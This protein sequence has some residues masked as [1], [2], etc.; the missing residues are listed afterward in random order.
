VPDSALSQYFSKLD[1]GDFKGCADLFSDDALY[2][3]PSPSATNPDGTVTPGALAFVSGR[4][5]IQAFFEEPGKR[6]FHHEIRRGI[7][8]TSSSYCEGLVISE[9]GAPLQLFISDALLDSDGRITRYVG[10]AKEVT[11][12]E[13]GQLDVTAG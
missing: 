5:A 6:S 11:A 4:Q 7:T 10:L 13:A 9:D 1:A 2:V 3:R 12:G 8:D